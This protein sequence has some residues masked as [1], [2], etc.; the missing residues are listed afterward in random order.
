MAIF[1]ASEPDQVFTPRSS[2]VNEQMYVNRELLEE[3]F[4]K[5]I[6]GGKHIIVH[7]ESGNGKTWLYKKVFDNNKVPYTVINLA[8][9]SRLGGLQRAFEDKLQKKSPDETLAQ[10]VVTV[11]GGANVVLHA[12]IADERIYEIAK[13]E[14]LEA[15]MA[16]LHRE[17]NSKKSFIV[18]DNLE[19][20]L[21]NHDRVKELSDVLILLDDDDYA[22]YNVRFCIVG[23]PSDIREYLARQSSIETITNRTMELSEVARLT[24]EEANIVNHRFRSIENRLR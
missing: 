24:D 22:K 1:R 17:A 19:Q 21:T 5:H 3:Q 14:P 20:I 2:V 13:R 10:H 15:L 7:G 18:L 6:F 9:A 16:L 4:S 11:S 8:T 12:G 23:V